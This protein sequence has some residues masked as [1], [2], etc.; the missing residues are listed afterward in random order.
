AESEMRKASALRQKSAR[1]EAIDA[2]WKRVFEAVGVGSE[3]GPDSNTVKDLCFAVESKIV[4]NQILDGEPRIDGR[5][6]RT[7]RPITIR[8]GVLTRTHGYTLFT[9]GESRAVV[10]A[11]LGSMRAG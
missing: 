11:A 10:V 2:I 9:R 6:T 3:G 7:V 8:N 5:D 4:R 1:S